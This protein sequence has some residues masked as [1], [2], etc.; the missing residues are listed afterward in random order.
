M[1]CHATRPAYPAVATPAPTARPRATFL[2]PLFM[3]SVLPLRSIAIHR[4]KDVP[5][6]TR[7]K[8]RV[9]RLSTPEYSPRREKV[10]G[11]DARETGDCGRRTPSLRTQSRQ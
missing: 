5:L 10:R 11:V 6:E 9:G 2:S 3:M 1:R 4:A 8:A 7:R